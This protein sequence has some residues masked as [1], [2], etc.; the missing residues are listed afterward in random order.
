MPETPKPSAEIGA[1][2][3]RLRSE[4]GITLQEFGDRTGIAWQ[5]LQAYETGRVTPPTDRFLVILHHV[6][7]VQ[8]PFHLQRVA[9][10]CAAA[11]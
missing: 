3:R 2:I 6:R 11:A 5:T 9:A 4:L 7:R 10:V 1:E 8:K